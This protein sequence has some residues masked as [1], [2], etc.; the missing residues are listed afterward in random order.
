MSKISKLLPIACPTQGHRQFEQCIH[1]IL[2]LKCPSPNSKYN[3]QTRYNERAGNSRNYYYAPATGREFASNDIVL[4]LEISM[5]ANEQYNDR[6]GDEC[7]SKRFPD[8]V[9]F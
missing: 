7:G 9:Q 3:N 1:G 4:A 5:E 2:I 6:N 8:V